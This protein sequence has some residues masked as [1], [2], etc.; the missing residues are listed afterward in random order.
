MRKGFLAILC[1]AVAATASAYQRVPANDS[2]VVIEGVRHIEYMD[3]I[4]RL[5]R[6][7]DDLWGM[8]NVRI[9]KIKAR[10]QTGAA[11]VFRTDSRSVKPLF[12]PN[13]EGEIKNGTNWFGIYR[14]GQFLTNKQGND[15]VLEGDGSMTEWI[16]VMPISCA[17]DYSGLV[18]DDGAKLGKVSRPARPVYFSIGDSITHGVGQTRSGSQISYPYVIAQENGYLL[19]NLAVGG[20]QISPAIVSELEGMKIDV[21]TIMWGFNDWNATRGDLEEIGSRYTALLEGI[22]KV[23]PEAEV[24]CILP[25]PSRHELGPKPN[26]DG[27]PAKG[28]PY[29]ATLPQVR[30]LQRGIAQ[31]FHGRMKI[32]ILE[33]YTYV[34][35]DDLN[36]NVHFTND[37]AVKFGKAAAADIR[38][39]LGK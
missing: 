32:H 12:V 18:L 38:A 7:A 4:A 19:Y 35:T 3:S 27:S 13:P 25:S 5:K 30:E 1:L 37:G 23:Q 6:H 14:N 11:I 34:T 36:G 26:K 16:I 28:K 9:A 20:S 15:I 21:I 8:E 24:F 22:A 10:N 39:A 2:R 31:N 29:A 33:G 17:Y